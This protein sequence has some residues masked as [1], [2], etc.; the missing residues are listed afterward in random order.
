MAPR[1]RNPLSPTAHLCES[2]PCALTRPVGGLPLDDRAGVHV[3]DDWGLAL[4]YAAFKASRSGSVAVILTYAMQG[5]KLEPD[6]DAQVDQKHTA[7]EAAWYIEEFDILKDPENPDYDRL[8]DVLQSAAEARGED[9]AA[10]GPPWSVEAELIRLSRTPLEQVLSDHL[11]GD[12]AEAA[13]ALAAVAE[14]KA[15]LDYHAE[16]I[17]QWRTFSE[18]GDERLVKVEVVRPFYDEVSDEDYPDEEPEN[19]PQRLYLEDLD[20]IPSAVE[21]KTLFV[22]H[23]PRGARL[24]YHGTDLARA[25]QILADAGVELHNPWAPVVQ[26][27][28]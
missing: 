15:P 8:A 9:V 26:P 14:D 28:D 3:T 7:R 4:R 22:R 19:E 12:E 6:F 5:L 13:R 1:V 23:P 21:T 10:E 25:E 16:A 11:R 18:V 2:A 20:D 24:Y 17:H 27:G